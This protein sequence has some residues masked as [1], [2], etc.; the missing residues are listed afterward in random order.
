MKR[1]EQKEE[2]IRYATFE[3]VSQ[4]LSLVEPFVRDG[5]LLKRSRRKIKK[6]IKRKELRV[7]VIEDSTGHKRKE[8]IKGFC[9]CSIISFQKAEL[10]FLAAK[11]GNPFLAERL[12]EKWM[13]NLKILQIDFV[14]LTTRIDNRMRDTVFKRCGF[15]PVSLWKLPLGK[16][17][18]LVSRRFLGRHSIAMG[19]NL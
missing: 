17:I 4:I 13:E 14:F 18:A 11:K 9:A 6:M 5:W 7:A 3:D 19:R 15:E 12:I 8:K 16:L 10:Y 2:I 1:T